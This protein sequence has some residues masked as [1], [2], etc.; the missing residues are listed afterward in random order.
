MTISS[1]N[2][3]ENLDGLKVIAAF[4][5]VAMHVSSNMGHPLT[6]KIATN[7]IGSM[8]HFVKL[9]LIL[10]GFGMCCGYYEM[11]KSGK[12]N[13]EKF[14]IRRFAKN[15]PFFAL[16]IFIDTLFSIKTVLW[17]D[18]FASLTMA[19]NLFPSHDMS[20]IGVSWTLGVIFV[21]YFM[22]P[23]YVFLISTTKRAWLTMIICF[24]LNWCCCDYY[25]SVDKT[26]GANFLFLSIYFVIGGVLYLYRERI[27]KKVSRVPK[28]LVLLATAVIT[29]IWYLIPINEFSFFFTV[30]TVILFAMWIVFAIS[31]PTKLLKNNITKTLSQVSLEVYLSHMMVFRIVEKVEIINRINNGNIAY[32]IVLFLTIALTIAFALIAKK[33]IDICFKRLK[34]VER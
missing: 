24:I 21:F 16:L 34:K 6:S 20:I 9:F 19:F 29:I 33:V 23:F 28:F 5:I 8:T 31:Q 2:R 27:Q 26:D 30:K 10:S 13:L 12:V 4:G 3:Y 7:I 25:E 14:Y 18:V 32:I 22:F 17:R 15:V 1:N 11:F